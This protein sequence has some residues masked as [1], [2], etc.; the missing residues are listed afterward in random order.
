MLF[1]NDRRMELANRRGMIFTPEGEFKPGIVSIEGDVIEDVVYVT[2]S[3]LTKEERDLYIIP[4]LI[5]IHMHGCNGHDACSSGIEGIQSIIAYERDHGITSICLATMTLDENSLHRALR[6]IS[7]VNNNNL[8]GIYLEGPFING[9]KRGAHLKEHISAPDYEMLLRLRESARDKIKLVA[10]APEVDGAFTC[11]EKARDDFNFT[12]AHSKADYGVATRAF[13]AG[14]KHVTHLYN[15]MDGLNHRSPG[16]IGAASDNDDV[17]VELITD[18]IHVHPS[19][20]RSTFKMFGGDRIVLV[21]DSMEATGMPNGVYELGGQN[22]NVSNR[23]ALLDDG[24]IAGSAT[25][26]FDCMHQAIKMGIDKSLAIK[27]VTANPA[28]AIGIYDS[29]GS[30]EVGKKADILILDHDFKLVEVIQELT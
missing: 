7:S 11:V 14:V 2:E 23:W 16:I 17:M 26:L 9:E 27:A 5:D 22:V 3:E 8:K 20:V 29:V 30:I 10:I 25:N 19:V 15:A 24:T 6:V 1:Y 28:K 13:E 12:I 18:G 21:S 4:G